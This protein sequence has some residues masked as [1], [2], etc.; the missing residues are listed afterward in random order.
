MGDLVF[1]LLAVVDPQELLELLQSR[2]GCSFCVTCLRKEL[3]ILQQDIDTIEIQQDINNAT[4]DLVLVCIASLHV[5]TPISHTRVKVRPS[6][7]QVNTQGERKPQQNA[8]LTF[9]GE[10][11]TPECSRGSLEIVRGPQLDRASWCYSERNWRKPMYI[12]LQ[13]GNRR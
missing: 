2:H 13:F 6:D 10:K 8:I 3:Q 4:G 1:Q 12:Y 9:T 11:T 5:P 7:A